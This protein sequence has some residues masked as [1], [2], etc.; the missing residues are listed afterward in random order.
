MSHTAKK[1]VQITF[2]CPSALKR[3]CDMLAEAAM[4]TTS[5]YMFDIMC[6][7]LSDKSND[8]ML[9]KEVFGDNNSD[10]SNNSDRS[11]EL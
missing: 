6:K 8:Y 2:H 1:D 10:N 7:H 9:L 3:Q 11:V 4:V 5:Q